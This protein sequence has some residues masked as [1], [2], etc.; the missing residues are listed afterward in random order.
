ME[1]VTGIPTASVIAGSYLAGATPFAYLVAR[2]KGIDIRKV[3]S[4]N[5]GATNVFRAVGKGWGALTFACDMLKGLLPALLGPRLLEAWTGVPAHPAFGLA[6][7]VAAIAG[8]SWPVF[9]GFK[10]GK[11][12]ATSAGML[13]GAA[14]LAA[15]VG[16]GLWAAVFLVTRYVSVASI[17]AAVGVPLAGWL[18]YGR[19][20]L[21]RPWILT[22]IGMLVIFRHRSNVQRLLEGA[23]HR[24]GRKGGERGDGSGETNTSQPA[25]ADQSPSGRLET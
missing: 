24:F 17:S 2:A 7:G 5:V 4:G 9:L 10:G 18:A 8:H 16:F 14:P 1:R 21:W 23:E 3:G 11:G 19:T 22:A 6:C 15:A 13:L 12:V 25:N 20:D